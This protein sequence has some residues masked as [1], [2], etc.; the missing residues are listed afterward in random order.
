MGFLVIRGC[1]SH[2]D[3]CN[4]E[5]V[6]DVHSI[7]AHSMETTGLE[8][9]IAR[10]VNRVLDS[11]TVSQANRQHAMFSLNVRCDFKLGRSRPKILT[12]RL[13]D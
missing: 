5:H 4:Y 8:L 7:V 10:E 12:L 1:K 11:N 2:K 6:S 13:P 3:T 9:E